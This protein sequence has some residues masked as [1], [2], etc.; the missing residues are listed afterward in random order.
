M[1]RLIEDGLFSS[2]FKLIN[3]DANNKNDGVEMFRRVMV[4]AVNVNPSANETFSI[5]TKTYTFKASGSTGDQ[6]DIGTTRAITIANIVTKINLD[7]V[8]T[9]CL[10]YSIANSAKILLVKNALNGI[11]PLFVEDGDKV[12][13]DFAWTTDIAE[14]KLES[15]N[16]FKTNITLDGAAKPVTLTERNAKSAT[17]FLY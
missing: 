15:V 8:S 6:I 3:Y 4:V 16:Y 12:N 13:E 7:R 2:A 1:L 11:D 14:A 9:G 17:N 5:G 10:A